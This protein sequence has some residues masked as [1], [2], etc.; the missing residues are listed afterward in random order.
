M[1]EGDCLSQCIGGELVVQ[2]LSARVWT[3]TALARPLTGCQYQV[4]LEAG[5][6]KS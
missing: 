1:S 5:D 4:T 2:S 3:F 6:S